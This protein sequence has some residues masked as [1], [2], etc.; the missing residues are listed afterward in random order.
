M[1]IDGKA[2]GQ[3]MRERRIELGLSATQVAADL[4][5]SVEHYWKIEAGTRSPSLETIALF[6]ER[7]HIS[8]D[9]LIFG[10]THNTK[11][12]GMIDFVIN[13]L[14]LVRDNMSTGRIWPSF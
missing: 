12:R 5:F 11:L 2:I 9:Y 10:Q 4:N 6:S 14:I 3:R 1:S 8:T 13:L 7:Y